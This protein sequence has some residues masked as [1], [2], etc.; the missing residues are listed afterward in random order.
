M[1]EYFAYPAA[2]RA[3]VVTALTG[4]FLALLGIPLML[5]RR[6][7][8][9]VAL[10]EAAA[11][12]SALGASIA[13]PKYAAPLAVTAAVLVLLEVSRTRRTGED[14]PVAL[15]YLAASSGATLF[16]SKLPGGDADMM[17]L[18][19]GNILATSAFE[20]RTG[21]VV[22]V[23]GIAA[24]FACAVRILAV[25]NDQASA[26]AA[27]VHPLRLRLA[28]AVLLAIGVTFGLSVCGVVPVVAYL[29]G[30]AFVGLRVASSVVGWSAAAA[31]TAT[32]VSVVGLPASFAWDFPP[33]PFI[34]C[35]MAIV[36]I[37]SWAMRR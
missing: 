17:T 14:G 29:V 2:F 31:F 6:A 9:G 36:C 24:Y 5:R 15:C 16:L 19:F 20:V 32:V 21:I 27:G 1:S 28:Y 7:F 12:G 10:A 4:T 3:M 34:A 30:P 37:V 22:A 26:R 33:G 13:A 8:T 35:L 11:L 23:A 25:L 18:H